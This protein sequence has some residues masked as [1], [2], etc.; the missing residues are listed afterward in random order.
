MKVPSKISNHKLSLPIFKNFISLWIIELFKFLI[1]QLRRTLYV[2]LLS[3]KTPHL[4]KQ[5]NLLTNSLTSITIDY[6][7]IWYGFPQL[8]S[9][10]AFDEACY[11]RGSPG[12]LARYL[13]NA[14]YHFFIP[15][16]EDGFSV[17]LGAFISKNDLEKII[18]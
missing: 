8:L 4:R 18:K 14:F 3:K 5:V 13:Y 10:F 15:S 6:I 2:R 1:I 12:T 9:K 7:S 11:L 16:V 17:H